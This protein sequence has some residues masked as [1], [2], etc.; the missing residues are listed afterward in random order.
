[1]TGGAALPVSALAELDENEVA[2]HHIQ[3]GAVTY[4]KLAPNAVFTNTIVVSPVGPT[5]KDNCFQLLAAL[6]GIDDAGI[7]NQ[8]LIYLEPGIYDCGPD[9]VALKPFVTIQGAGPLR[10]KIW[11]LADGKLGLVTLSSDSELRD[12]EVLNITTP[13]GGSAP[14]ITTAIGTDHR[15]SLMN[16]RIENVVANGSGG[17][18]E[19]HGIFLDSIGNCVGGME[20]VQTRAGNSPSA[21]ALEIK[22]NRG[23][24]RIDNL[25]AISERDRAVFKTDNAE[26]IIVNSSISGGLDLGDAFPVAVHITNGAIHFANTQLDGSV[27]VTDGATAA[28]TCVHSYDETFAP[29]TRAARSSSRSSRAFC[30]PHSRPVRHHAEQR[31][32]R[33][34]AKASGGSVSILASGSHAPYASPLLCGRQPMTHDP[35][36]DPR[37]RALL[38]G[39]LALA[40]TPARAET[41]EAFMAR[42]FALRD[43]ALA[44]G[45]Q[46]YGA[47]VVLDGALVGEGPSRVVTAS[48]PTAHAEMEAIRHGAGRLGTGGLAGAIMYSSSRPCPMCEAAAYWAGIGKLVYGRALSDGGAP[49]LRR[50]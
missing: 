37:R 30:R 29:V 6:D 26:V 1:M 46:G 12:L 31:P 13:G 39:G 5:R 41:P 19:F 4:A 18:E 9:R 23:A 40:A 21:F 15:F 50:C 25:R 3:D 42:A 49:R 38:L 48:D 22:C 36:C 11:G 16:W 14:R 17:R 7:D 24:I 32:A 45:D 34:V 28:A 20:N 47:I 43:E 2:T 10:T 8:Y 27:L 44:A 35:I 33:S